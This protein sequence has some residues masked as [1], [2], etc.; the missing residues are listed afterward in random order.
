MKWLGGKNGLAYCVAASVMKENFFII[1]TPG[2]KVIKLFFV[3]DLRIFV[4]S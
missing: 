4:L 2:A 1:S 3:R